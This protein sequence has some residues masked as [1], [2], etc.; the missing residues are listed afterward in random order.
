MNIFGF[1]DQEFLEIGI[2]L[3]IVLLTL[4]LAR[5]ILTFILDRIIKR[6]TKSTKS[7][8]DDLIIEAVRTPLFWWIFILAFQIALDRLDFVTAGFDSNL[9]D[10]YF[11][12]YIVMGFILTWRLVNTLIEWY[13][14]EVAPRTDSALDEQLVPF[15]RRIV[16]IL[17]G[18]ITAII[19]LGR[20]DV[21]VSGLVTTLG[22]GSL[23]VALAAQA[24]LSDTISGFMIMFD[25]PFRIGDRIEIQ[26]LDTWGDV[27]DIGLRSTRIRTRDNRMVI[28]P[29]SLIGKSLVVNHSY[30]STQYRIQIELGVAYDSDIEVARNTIIN[31]V[32]SVEG[33][34][35]DKQVEAL[36]LRFGDSALIFRVRWWIE[37]YVDT[38]RM[39]DRVNT[40]MYKTLTE[41][42]IKMPFPTQEVLHKIEAEDIPQFVEVFRRSE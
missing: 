33:V 4:I 24:A 8:L 26:D 12:L 13:G 6:I 38:R 41:A 21:E 35:Q 28:I 40:A 25:R 30:P 19:V 34:L 1:S 18:V 9:E 5:P 22:I 23:A 16:L 27:V 7:R 17:L 29:N 39:F 2:S 14:Q 11:T 15:M 20:F 31:A 36:L 42:G 37:S 32:K 10:L 3:A